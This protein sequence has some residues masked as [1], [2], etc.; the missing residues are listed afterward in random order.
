[1]SVKLI[2]FLNMIVIEYSLSSNLVITVNRES[3]FFCEKILEPEV[4]WAP[5][6]SEI[7]ASTDPTKIS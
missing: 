4:Q 3:N 7:F 6:F 1:M 2:K 5:I